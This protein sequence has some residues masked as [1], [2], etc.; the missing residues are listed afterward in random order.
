VKSEGSRELRLRV[1]TYNVH[2][3]VGIDG[4]RSESRIA[5]VIADLNVDIIGLQELD[6]DRR[7]SAGTDQAGLIAEQLGWTRFFHPA[8][9]RAE[10]KYGDAILSRYPMNL[11]QAA[12]LPGTAPFYCR[13]TRGAL[14]ATVA[15]PL[16]QIHVFNTHFGLGRKE[17]L[18][19]AQLLAGPD[20]LGRVP[21]NEST[22]ILGDFN[23]TVKSPPYQMLARA[24]RDARSFI[25]PPP[26][27]R[28]YPTQWPLV[29][30]DH[31]FLSSLLIARTVEV[32]SSLQARIA[33]DH[34][35]VVA[36][37]QNRKSALPPEDPA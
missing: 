14:W 23:S 8:M 11:R 9:Q 37:I 27:L 33:S 24:M 3:C 5:K 35:P 16:G 36:E 26:A 2:G 21:D 7:R 25:N 18:I 12:L 19:Q 32:A 34:F 29:G 17:R 28:S 4:R 22:I 1:A 6:L 15:T 30:V 31:I 10:E 20:W 13:E